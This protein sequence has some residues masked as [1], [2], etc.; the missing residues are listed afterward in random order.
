METNLENRRPPRVET[1]RTKE[2]TEKRHQD[3]HVLNAE[4]NRDEEGMQ[5]PDPGWDR[6]TEASTWEMEAQKPGIR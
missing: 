5:C 6:Q 3:S 2:G 1:G 4:G